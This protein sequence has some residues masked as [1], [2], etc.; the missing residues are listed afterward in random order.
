MALSSKMRYVGIALPKEDHIVV[1]QL[2]EQ[3]STRSGEYV[4]VSRWIAR[5]VKEKIKLAERHLKKA[6]Q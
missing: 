3:E 5:I 6:S 4:S 1:K 2:A